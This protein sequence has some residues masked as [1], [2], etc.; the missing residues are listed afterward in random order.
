MKQYYEMYNAASDTPPNVTSDQGLHCLLIGFS[1]KT[2]KN[3]SNKIN[4]HH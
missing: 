1:I 3:K 2:R 4:L